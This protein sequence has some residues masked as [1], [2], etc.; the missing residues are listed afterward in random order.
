MYVLVAVLLLFACKR[1]PEFPTTPEISYVSIS[2]QIGY[3]TA[4]NF[5]E[6]IDSVVI[7]IKFKD[8]NGDLGTEI[9]G[10]DNYMCAVFFK[11]SVD[12]LP[13]VDSATGKILDKNGTFRPLNTDGLEGPIEGT[14]NYGVTVSDLEGSIYDGREK[15]TLKFQVSI[16]DNAGHKS[17]MIETDPID[18]QFY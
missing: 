1:P 9:Q 4:G 13:I 3:V 12:F 14:L 15:Y 10:A 7:S 16:K 6:K 11:D 8:G 18:I 5:T 17:N 2:K